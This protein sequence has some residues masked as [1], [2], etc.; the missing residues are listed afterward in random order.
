M[1]NGQWV[2]FDLLFDE[3]TILELIQELLWP[4][5]CIHLTKSV[6]DNFAKS[7]KI[8]RKFW[9]L[10][11]FFATKTSLDEVSWK[12][13]RER[14]RKVIVFPTANIFNTKNTS[15]PHLWNQLSLNWNSEFFDFQTVVERLSIRVWSS[16]H[17]FKSHACCCLAERTSFLLVFFLRVRWHRTN[18]GLAG[19]LNKMGSIFY[20]QLDARIE[21]RMPGKEARTLPLCYRVRARKW[22]NFWDGIWRW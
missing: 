15:D 16:R 10:V 22:D 20:Q 19:F 13:T 2:T 8:C 18:F 9:P 7:C 12:K 4:L 3:N 5:T 17:G 1:V 21:P 14:K 11:D 6:S